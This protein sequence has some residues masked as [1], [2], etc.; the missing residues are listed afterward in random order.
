[1]QQSSN[2]ALV[3]SV[4]CED[5]TVHEMN[6]PDGSLKVIKAFFF[7]GTKRMSLISPPL[8]R[9]VFSK[10]ID[11]ISFDMVGGTLETLTV[12]RE[13]CGMLVAG[14]VVWLSGG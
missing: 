10:Y 11:S 5:I 13:C 3:V 6:A 1:M 14:C 4:H 2:Y 8:E 7:S 12:G 9:L